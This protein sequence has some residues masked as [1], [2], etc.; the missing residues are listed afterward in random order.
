M[1]A[2][3][4]NRWFTGLFRGAHLLFISGKNC[5]WPQGVWPQPIA[6]PLCLRFVRLLSNHATWCAADGLR[7]LPRRCRNL[8]RV[9]A[10]TQKLPA[11]YGKTEIASFGTPTSAIRA[12]ATLSARNASGCRSI[13]ALAKI[14]SVI[15]SRPVKPWL[16]ALLSFFFRLIGP[17]IALGRRGTRQR[18]HPHKPQ[19]YR[20]V[21]GAAVSASQSFLQSLPGDAQRFG[22]FLS[23]DSPDARQDRAIRVHPRWKSLVRAPAG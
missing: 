2:A 7:R 15:R 3:P 8:R 23:T 18:V 10:A 22:Q 21:R 9:P 1:R 13:A 16:C 14:A 4:E 19:A 5:S 6:C 12:T 17:V 20:E 11:S